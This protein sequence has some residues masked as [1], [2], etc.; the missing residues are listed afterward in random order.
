MN[1]K[2]YLSGEIHTPWRSSIENKCLSINL[3]IQFYYPVTEHSVSDDCGVKILG[4]EDK[5]FW[6]DYKGASM[7]SVRISSLIKKS[8]FV[9]IKFGE[10]YRQWNA[11]FDAGVAHNLNKPIITF[12]DESL[13]HALK[14]IDSVANIVCRNEDQVVQ[15]LKYITNGLI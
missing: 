4:S 5:K 14:E 1:Y 3:P 10:K 6:H 7:N 2:I 13:D 11:A 12:H 8:D 9:I 15:S